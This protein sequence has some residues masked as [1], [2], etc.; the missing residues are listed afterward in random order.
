[1]RSGGGD[2][3]PI[4]EGT[5]NRNI[6]E[7]K[8]QGNT[9]RMEE[10]SIEIISDSKCDATGCREI[11]HSGDACYCQACYQELLDRIEELEKELEK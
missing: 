4:Y 9:G 11:L 6:F 7:G 2:G 10:M 8:E 1:M 5:Q 3:R